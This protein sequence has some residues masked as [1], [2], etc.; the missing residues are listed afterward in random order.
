MFSFPGLSLCKLA[1]LLLLVGS[2]V[3]PVSYGLAV[4][5]PTVQTGVGPLWVRSPKIDVEAAA[6]EARGT[7]SRYI[8]LVEN[9]CHYEKRH[10]YWRFAVR[11]NAST[12][13]QEGSQ[14]SLEFDP[15]Y[16]APVFHHIRIHR[17]GKVIDVTDQQ[18]FKVIQREKSHDR[19]IYDNRLTALA[20]VEGT[21]VGDIIDYAYSIQGNNPVYGDL[22]HWEM[23]TSYPVK[24]GRIIGS[25]RHPVNDIVI[26]RST[27][28]RVNSIDFPEGDD[29][30][31]YWDIRDPEVIAMEANTPDSFDYGATVVASNAD[32]WKEIQQWAFDLFPIP[33]TL[34]DEIQE[35]C[36][37]FHVIDGE[38]SVAAAALRFVQDEIRYLGTFEGVHTHQPYSLEEI[39]SRR[40]G[41]C[42]DKAILLTSM[43]RNLGIRA[44]PAL[45][46]TQ[47]G[48]AVTSVIPSVAA[49]DH[50][51][52]KIT[53]DQRD[54]WVDPTMTF[55][56][57]ELEYL[58]FPN[59]GA[60]LPL[61]EE[62]GGL[63]DIHTFNN[64]RNG[65][66]VT[67]EVTLEN[68]SGEA[69][70]DIKTN[71]TGKYADF[72]RAIFESQP[73][74]SV[75]ELHVER[76]K[77]SYPEL[78]V[79]APFQWKEA[80]EHSIESSE[81]YKIKHFGFPEEKNDQHFYGI[82]VADSV[83]EYLEPELATGRTLPLGVEHPAK[84]WSS[85]KVNFPEAI[86]FQKEFEAIENEFFSFSHSVKPSES[87]FE[88]TCF[89]QSK[90]GIIPVERLEEYAKEAQKARDLCVY[91][92][93]VNRDSTAQPRGEPSSLSSQGFPVL[94]NQP[95]EEH[96]MA[97]P[98]T[99][100]VVSRA[101][102]SPVSVTVWFC[103][104]LF[105]VAL[106]T[107]AALIRPKPATLYARD[108]KLNGLSG[109]LILQAMNLVVSVFSNGLLSILAFLTALEGT[110]DP[111][112]FVRFSPVVLFPLLVV[113]VARFF[114]R[115][116]TAPLLI[117]V[118]L[119]FVA[120]DNVALIAIEN[121][122]EA[123]PFE[124]RPV[125]TGA[126]SMVSILWIV[127]FMNSKRVANTFRE[128]IPETSGQAPLNGIGEVRTHSA[129][130]M[131]PP[132]LPAPAQQPVKKE[133]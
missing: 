121:F 50:V 4:E 31:H 125:R 126:V 91:N 1:L 5:H 61:V 71:N 85:V 26:P 30:V 37:S 69:T 88:F 80:K 25:F 82:A 3:L 101:V 49:F 94:T 92:F 111:L 12:G 103:C 118:F 53:I 87:G 52:V 62:A 70:L 108:E 36:D 51:V 74:D 29:V 83:A 76:A 9:H 109:W 20:I 72:F 43:L 2:T 98:Q 55:Q 56:R 122:S 129:H 116:Y 95:S 68:F 113:I 104:F 115:H 131:G 105:G 15:S 17:G 42:K 81:R 112:D 110:Q 44:C 102:S 114:Q 41:D 18:E 8:V 46:N 93:F 123:V 64:S 28:N 66:Y 23:Q 106:A 73:L 10:K 57:G 16:Q 96:S 132:P 79:D 107:L 133:P 99:A 14:I 54:F 128:G 38:K 120:L 75:S 117:C 97:T 90:A 58:Y 21:R 65:R 34:P 33:E 77:L 59:Y 130:S 48:G 39:N 32:D 22:F 89:Y 35:V 27:G 60:A 124:D 84:M 40:Y 78:E 6:I 11:L 19:Q 119:L 86:Q 67:K 100:T 13:V 47:I 63:E 45:V 7:G 24:V 127:Y